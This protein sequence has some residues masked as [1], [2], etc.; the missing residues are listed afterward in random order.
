[1]CGCALL[2]GFLW[3]KEEPWIVFGKDAKT[4]STHKVCMWT[5]LS[6]ILPFV[7]GLTDESMKEFDLVDLVCSVNV[8]LVL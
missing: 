8:D 7:I 6:F 5:G 4:F 1:M 2:Y 3:L